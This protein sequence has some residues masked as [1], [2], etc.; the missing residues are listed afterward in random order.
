MVDAQIEPFEEEL[1]LGWFTQICLGLRYMHQRNIIH[2]DISTENVFI[3]DDNTAKIGN[4]EQCLFLTTDKKVPCKSIAEL[5]CW[6]ST[7][8]RKN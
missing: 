5:L 1:I 8:L 6:A 4:F 7:D 2:R 3:T